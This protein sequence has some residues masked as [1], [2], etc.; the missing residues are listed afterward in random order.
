MTRQSSP[1][2]MIYCNRPDT[3]TA[4]I[5]PTLKMTA[6]DSV[7]AM[8]L[9]SALSNFYSKDNKRAQDIFV[10]FRKFRYSCHP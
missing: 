4:T 1:D 6:D 10:T 2:K 8:R 5:P 3:A 7:F 9:C